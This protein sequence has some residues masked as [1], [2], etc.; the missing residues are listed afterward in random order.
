MNTEE[1]NMGPESSESPSNEEVLEDVPEMNE[2]DVQSVDE[3]MMQHLDNQPDFYGN[4]EDENENDFE[5]V[6][7]NSMMGGEDY[8]DGDILGHS[9]NPNNSIA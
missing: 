8:Q 7:E 2:D 5:T 3:E 4:E 1:Q 6:G 9:N